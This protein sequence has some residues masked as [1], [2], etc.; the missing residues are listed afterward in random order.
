MTATAVTLMAQNYTLTPHRFHKINAICREAGGGDIIYLRG[1][2]YDHAPKTI[3]CAGGKN[4]FLTIAAYPGETPIIKTGWRIKGRWLH[5]KG[6]HFRGDADSLDYDNV[7]DHW[8]RPTKAMRQGGLQAQVRHLVIE[9]CAFGYF[10]SYGLKVTKKSDYVTIH[11]NIVYDNA[12]WSTAGTGGLVIKN[13][14]QADN[15]P[16]TKI[17][18]EN[19]LF[20]G[21]ESRIVSHVFKKG[22]TAM[23]ID[24]GYSFLIQEKD[25]ATK[26]GV[27]SGHYNGRYLAKNN[28]ILFNGKGLSVNKAD[29]VQLVAND[30][31]ANG[32]TAT[33]PK[34]AG[35]RVNKDAF[36]VLIE[37]NA[38]ETRGNGIAYSVPAR[39]VRL[40]NNYA[41]SRHRVPMPGVVYVDKLFEDPQHLNFY[42][43]YFKDRANRLLKSFKPM[44]KRWHIT[45]EPTGY[46]V[47]L[48]RQI[49]DIVARIPKTKKTRV[50]RKNGAIY[51]Y[52]IDNR[53]I[54]GLGK[55]YVLKL[56]HR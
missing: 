32:T 47:D 14:V 43:P 26:K 39:K 23:T 49:K 37:D 18:I 3:R 34:A 50:V 38:V 53:G 35:I 1:G 31:Y 17:K 54:K 22:F 36:K 56:R 46:R 19:N 45:V 48:L 55:N 15:R 33:S 51:I 6:L 28:L 24:E 44:L 8:W 16:D 12:W 52:D 11:H 25:D 27:K 2:I 42:N 29:R 10:P 13:I 21:N 41:K 9:D 4:S 7:I 40:K 30:L 5:L 20:F